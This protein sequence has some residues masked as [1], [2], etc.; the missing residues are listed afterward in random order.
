MGDADDLEFDEGF[1]AFGDDDFL[2]GE[3]PLDESGKVGFGLMDGDDAHGS[4]LVML[5][6]HVKGG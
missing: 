2:S 1:M 6:S 4:N 3:G 5:V